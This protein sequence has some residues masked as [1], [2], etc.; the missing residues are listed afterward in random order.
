MSCVKLFLSQ[1]LVPGFLSTGGLSFV[2][3][4]V[5]VMAT[6]ES[7]NSSQMENPEILLEEL[8]S[9]ILENDLVKSKVLVGKIRSTKV[10]NIK[11]VKDILSKAWVSCPDAHIEDLGKNVFLFCFNHEEEAS[12]DHEKNSMVC[13]EPF[14]MF[15]E[16][17]T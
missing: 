11:A 16:V 5:M 7:S 9:D 3:V 13:N 15:G 8:S 6:P 12:V 1:F 17:E 4:C 14:T 10:C 2:S